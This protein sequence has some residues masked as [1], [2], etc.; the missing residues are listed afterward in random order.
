[1]EDVLMMLIMVWI[2]KL[3][4]IFSCV[5]IPF[6]AT[7]FRK[8]HRGE[9]FALVPVQEVIASWRKENCV[10][11]VRKMRKMDRVTTVEIE[12]AKQCNIFRG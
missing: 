5:Y 1:V 9:A 7:Y 8:P 10:P 12:S 6:F 2:E 4:I 11:S 3:S